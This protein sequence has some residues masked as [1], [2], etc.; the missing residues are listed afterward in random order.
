MWV[1]VLF[2]I[3]LITAIIKGISRGLVYALFSFVGLLLGLVAA[4]KLSAKV[5][6]YLQDSAGGGKWLPLLSFVLVFVAV[7]FL[8]R[9]LAALVEGALELS[10][11]GWLNRIGGALFYVAI[12]LL[13]FS[14]LLF[15]GDKMGLI[16]AETKSGSRFY[17]IIAP[18]GPW[19]ID[20][21]GRLVPVFRDMFEELERFFDGV[22]QRIPDPKA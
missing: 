13:F 1:D 14:V 18:L 17:S 19:V 6:S 15:F 20:G 21:I 4:M 22:E 5:A 2:I 3:V 10:L 7:V 8:V 12:D 9:W 16:G 11:L